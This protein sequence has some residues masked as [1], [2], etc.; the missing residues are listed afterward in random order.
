MIIL[1]GVKGKKTLT[2]LLMESRY[3]AYTANETIDFRGRVQ[4]VFKRRATTIKFEL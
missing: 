4:G 3:N 1:K 2:S